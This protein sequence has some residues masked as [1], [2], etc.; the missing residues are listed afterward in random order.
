MSILGFEV[1]VSI[2]FRLEL[3]LWGS[4]HGSGRELDNVTCI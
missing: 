4:W 3:G 1:E 2:G